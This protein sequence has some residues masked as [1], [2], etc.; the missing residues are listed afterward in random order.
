MKKIISVFL[1]TLLSLSFVSCSKKEEVPE[2]EVK[3]TWAGQYIMVDEETSEF[4]V[5]TVKKED[6]TEDVV[7]I[8]LRSVRDE[9]T[10]K[11]LL[12]TESKKYA[13]SNPGDR[14]LKFNLKS[15]ATVVAVD[16]IWTNKEKKRKENWSGTY[17][18]ID[19][20]TQPA[21]YGDPSWNG[22]YVSLENGINMSVYAIREGVVLL[23][24]NTLDLG[25]NTVKNHI[26]CEISGPS[27]REAIYTD[28]T[29]RSVKVKLVKKNKTVDIIDENNATGPVISGRY[30]R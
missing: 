28:E 22:E 14:C 27:R 9:D 8:S 3:D 4:K 15:T 16:D 17:K 2:E 10:F 18:L 7:Y 29:G 6:E 25:G 1:I 26:K 13:V 20:S 23:S 30:E 5:L 19:D 21:N 12:K 24:Y 11:T